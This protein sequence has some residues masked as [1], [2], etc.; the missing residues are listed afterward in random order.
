ML[1]E[2]A[3]KK[4][5]PMSKPYKRADSEGLYVLVKPSGS[6]LWRF[7]YSFRKKRKTLSFGA[8]PDVT[9]SVARKRR[10]AAKEQLTLGG[11][12]GARDKPI[13]ETTSPSFEEVGKLWFAARSNGWSPAH[14][15]RIS[16]RIEGDVYPELGRLAIDTIT[17]KMVLDTIRKI[18]DRGAIELAKRIKNY[19]G[20]IFRFAIPEGWVERDPTADIR[21][22]LKP[23]KRKKRRAFLKLSEMGEFRR[24]LTADQS[25]DASTKDA[26]ELTVLTVLRSMEIRFA[27]KRE[28]EG[29]GGP[30][31]LWRIPPARMK[32]KNRPAEHLVPLSRQAQNLVIRL[33]DR[34]KGDLILPGEAVAGVL[35][36]NT[37][38]FALYRLGYRSRATVHGFRSTFSTAANEAYDDGRRLWH[39]DA[40]ER[41]LAH[42]EEN[43]VRGSYNAAEYLP[44]RR[45]MMQWWA[46]LVWPDDPFLD[47]LG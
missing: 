37:M 45:R 39:P 25:L 43:E 35:S 24:R 42:V 4:L 20:E 46:D 41:Q 11:D 38:L 30:D 12:P 2:V 19:C 6:I 40:I 36:E 16:N 23:P 3:L 27:T 31:A 10:D 14:A 28:F 18:E 44:E 29:L 17:P 32:I 1:T 13:S 9:L 47:M 8:Y 5:K 22:A 26:L 15:V 21:D 33:I 34:A 7:D